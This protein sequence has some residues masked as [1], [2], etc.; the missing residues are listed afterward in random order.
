MRKRIYEK[1]KKYRAMEPM[2]NSF[3]PL[4]RNGWLIKLSVFDHEKTLILFVSQYTLQTIIRYFEDEV[5]AVK[6]INFIIDSDPTEEI[7]KESLPN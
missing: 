2:I 6:F 1:T 5:E 4:S 3:M 7:P